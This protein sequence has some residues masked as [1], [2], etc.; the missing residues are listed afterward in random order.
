MAV[1]LVN[2]ITQFKEMDGIRVG[3]TV[4]SKMNALERLNEI[5]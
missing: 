2:V 3:R 4:L 1:V 5:K